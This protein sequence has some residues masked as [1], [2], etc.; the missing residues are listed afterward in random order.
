MIRKRAHGRHK[1]RLEA[2]LETFLWLKIIK[3][4]KKEKMGKLKSQKGE[5][6]I[7]QGQGAAKSQ[8]NGRPSCYLKQEENN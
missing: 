8:P 1:L 6:E 3:K 7:I 4:K 5:E 2:A